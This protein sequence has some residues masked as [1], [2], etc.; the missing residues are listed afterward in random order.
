MLKNSEALATAEDLKDPFRP[1]G[2]EDQRHPCGIRAWGT[3]STHRWG[4]AGERSLLRLVKR[5]GEG[6]VVT[7]RKRRVGIATRAGQKGLS[8]LSL[9]TRSLRRKIISVSAVAQSWHVTQTQRQSQQSRQPHQHPK[10]SQREVRQHQSRQL[11]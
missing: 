8:L 9:R 7:K 4:R 1:P 10:R 11:Q 6:C 2:Y 3:P 5:R